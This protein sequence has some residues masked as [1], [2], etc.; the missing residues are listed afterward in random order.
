[1][2]FLFEK[3][4]VLDPQQIWLGEDGSESVLPSIKMYALQ[5]G[6][7]DPG[8]ICA[9]SLQNRLSSTG[10][11]GKS[12]EDW[13]STLPVGLNIS[14]TDWTHWMRKAGV[15][16]FKALYLLPET[17]SQ[18]GLP[19]PN[20]CVLRFSLHPYT[21]TTSANPQTTFSFK[22]AQ[23]QTGTLCDGTRYIF[24]PGFCSKQIPLKKPMYY[25]IV[26]K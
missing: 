13:W 18:S 26:Q 17:N 25:Q 15:A 11:G 2:A 5:K 20:V 16:K 14:G 12:S 3:I 8:D 23:S 10:T 22:E 21:K 19:S 1:M 24:C 4:K 7:L 6:F 9:I